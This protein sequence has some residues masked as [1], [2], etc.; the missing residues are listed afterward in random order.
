MFNVNSFLDSHSQYNLHGLGLLDDIVDSAN[1]VESTLGLV[2]VVPSQNLRES[3]DGLLEG[4]ELARGTG[5]DLG[6]VEGLTHETLDFAGAGDGHL[7]VLGELV[8]TKDGND[9]L[10]GLVVLEELLGVTGKEVVGVANH[11]G[12]KHPTGG[13]QGIDSGVDAKLGNRSGEHGGGIQ[14]SE[15]GRG[16]RIGKIIGGHI[17]GLH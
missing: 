14:M 12:V 17:D 10:E 6:D 3:P 1:H 16:G 11:T 7:V 13:V 5:E 2:V 4:D 8:H 15:G 9:V